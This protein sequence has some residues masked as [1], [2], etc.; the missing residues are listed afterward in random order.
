[1]GGKSHLPMTRHGQSPFGSRMCG[2]NLCSLTD[3][4]YFLGGYERD[5]RKVSEGDKAGVAQ[6]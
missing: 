2:G 3:S 6:H 4:S 1:M 5:G